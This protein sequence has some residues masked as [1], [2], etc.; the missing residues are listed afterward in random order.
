MMI[1]AME[2]PT[3]HVVSRDSIEALYAAHIPGLREAQ[4]RDQTFIIFFD[5]VSQ[6]FLK[7]IM[8][9]L[10]SALCNHCTRAC[11]MNVL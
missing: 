3:G 6:L 4:F 11:N 8:A 5:H 7:L 2:I 1:L 9:Y 10:S